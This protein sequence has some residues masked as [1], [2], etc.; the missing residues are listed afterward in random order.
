MILQ[1]IYSMKHMRGYEW[2]AV[3]PSRKKKEVLCDCSVDLKSYKTFEITTFLKKK[4]LKPE[5]NDFN[6]I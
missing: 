1:F 2:S 3:I 5:K 4:T 6:N